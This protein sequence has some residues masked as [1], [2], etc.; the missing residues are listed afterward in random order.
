MTKRGLAGVAAQFAD[1][2]NT[3]D[4]F[5]PVNW[6]ESGVG[7]DHKWYG[8][9]ASTYLMWDESADK[10]LTV[11]KVDVLLNGSAADMEWDASENLLKLTSVEIL[12]TA[13]SAST[14]STNWGAMLVKTGAD[15]WLK[16]NATS[17]STASYKYLKLTSTS[18]IS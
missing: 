2:E 12:G 9:T 15:I 10:L 11:G 5:N 16:I 3:L 1:P 7:A 4:I 13:S 6:G 17:L 18:V 14:V 8:T